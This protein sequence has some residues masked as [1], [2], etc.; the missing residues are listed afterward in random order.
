MIKDYFIENMQIYEKF[1]EINDNIIRLADPEGFL[2]C[3]EVLTNLITHLE[4]NIH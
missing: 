4:K 3:D 1:I 2:I